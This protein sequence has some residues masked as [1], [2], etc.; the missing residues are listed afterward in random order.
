MAQNWRD[1]E[2]P[3]FAEAKRINDPERA[4]E[5]LASDLFVET[6]GGDADAHRLS[7]P[8]ARRSR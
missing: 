1:A 2:L 4:L 5:Q 6:A 7:R 3:L 8:A